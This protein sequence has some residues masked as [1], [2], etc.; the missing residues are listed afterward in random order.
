MPR[1]KRSNALIH[2]CAFS[3]DG[4][5]A[6]PNITAMLS[7]VGRYSHQ[8]PRATRAG[9]HS[10]G[11][12]RRAVA[13]EPTVRL[14]TRHGASTMAATLA[15]LLSEHGGATG[16]RPQRRHSVPA[17]SAG[18]KSSRRW[19]CDQPVAGI[20]LMPDG[21]RGGADLRLWANRGPGKINAE[22]LR[23]TRKCR[24]S[25]LRNPQNSVVVLHDRTGPIPCPR[26]MFGRS[27]RAG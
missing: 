25:V 16:A 21:A 27:F 1:D 14:N 13:H 2:H 12:N 24:I 5:P 20:D 15:G 8:K 7:I 3:P 6:S 18:R 19:P 22:A 17:P 11:P 26:L 9:I 4:T 10:P 23:E